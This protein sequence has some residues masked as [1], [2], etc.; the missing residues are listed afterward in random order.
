MTGATA[1]SV[2]GNREMFAPDKAVDGQLTTSW[3]EGADDEAG[4]W[5]EVTFETARLDYVVVYGGF[6]LSHDAYLAN[7]RPKDVVVTVNGGAPLGFVLAD[8]EQP[9]RLDVGDVPAASVVRIEIVT[10]YDPQATAY[11][12]SPF[13]DMAISEIRAFGTP[14]G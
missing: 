9:Q 5:I 13:D 14:G 11:P 3:Q 6:Q 2:V 8:V 4:Q 1:S 7:R 12:G 10:T